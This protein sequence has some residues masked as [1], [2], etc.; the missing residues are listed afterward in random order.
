MS[1]SEEGALALLQQLVRIR[2][3]QPEGDESDL[4]DFILTLFP[5]DRIRT[6][7]IDHGRN[8]SS[9]VAAFPGKDNGRT[10]ALIGQ[11]DTHGLT[12]TEKWDFP[13]YR[14]TFR[15]GFVY[16][17]GTSNMKGGVASILLC[18]QSLLEA[19]ETLPVN[20]LLCL[21]ADGELNGTGARAMVDGGFLNDATE[22]IFVQ[23]TDG[24]IAIAQ[25]G[26]LWVR[27]IARGKTCHTCFP[28]KGAD[29]LEGLMLLFSL[30]NKKVTDSPV[31]H[32]YLGPPLC[33]LT[34]LEGRA[35]APN[36]IVDMGEA[37]MDLRL[38]P[39]QDN[40]EILREL[41]KIA[42]DL[43]ARQP[44]LSFKTEVMVN[45]PASTMPE[46]APLVGLLQKHLGDLGMDMT[47]TGMHSFSDV[48][49]IVPY[50]GAPFVI[51]GP[52]EDIVESTIN[53]KVSLSS[54]VDVA[55]ALIRHISCS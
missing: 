38:L 42:E 28:E 30:L 8:R 49:R 52:G 5:F 2:T 35:P 29:A 19:D 13:P 43:S 55:R 36:F 12:S 31:P 51:F 44:G 18:L 27:V 41:E 9:L 10:V 50:L 26:A 47:L 39:Y 54:V 32:T 45:R 24:R 16:G 33:N 6:N 14:A 46:D 22:L 11:M 7:I 40:G 17:R 53:E 23:P 15:S 4:L 1:V 34:L 25:K 37:V 20:V 3:H 21:T 48:S